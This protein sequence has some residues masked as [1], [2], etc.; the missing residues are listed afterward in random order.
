MDGVTEGSDQ[1]TTAIVVPPQAPATN[2]DVRPRV[3]LLGS[4]G[5]SRELAIALGRLG[6]WVIAV[7]KYASAPAHAVAAASIVIP[8]SSAGG[9]RTTWGRPPTRS[10]P[11]RSRAWGPPARNWYPA[12]APCGSPPTGR[13]CAGWPPTS[14]ACPPRWSGARDRSVS[15]RRWAHTPAIRCW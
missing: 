4:G 8:K 12:L 15:C 14:W 9:G 2:A 11:R 13:A 3:M 5:L 6:A 10:P 1:K 7:D